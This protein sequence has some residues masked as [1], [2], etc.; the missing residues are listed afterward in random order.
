MFKADGKSQGLTSQYESGCK[1]HES[2]RKV[3]ELTIKHCIHALCLAHVDQA[4]Q[5]CIMH[6]LCFT[7]LNY[8]EADYVR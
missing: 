1:I 2:V 8:N 4:E 5:Y 6:T 7:Q 3:A